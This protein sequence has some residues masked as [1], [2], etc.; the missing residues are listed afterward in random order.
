[1]PEMGQAQPGAASAIAVWP[2]RDQDAFERGQQELDSFSCDALSYTSDDLVHLTLEIFIALGFPNK[3]NISVMKLKKFILCVRTCMFDN[4]YHNWFHAFDVTQ[5]TYCLAIKSGMHQTLSDVELFALIVSALCH[6][7]EHPG[8][9]NPFLV[10]SRSDL[11]TLYN[12]RSVLENHHCCRAFQLILHSEIQLLSEFSGQDY[13]L[14]RTAVLSNI[15]ATDMARHGD[16]TTK[17]KRLTEASTP[18]EDRQIDSQFAMEVIIKCA[19]TSNVLKPFAIAKK[20]AMRV[21]DEFFLQGDKERANSMPLTPMCDRTS[22]GRVALQKGFVDFVI[23][24]FY[25]LV[26]DAMPGLKEGFF[27][28]WQNREA[29]NQYDDQRLL[30]ELGDDY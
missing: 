1:M 30:E 10:A 20:W 21:T 3:V 4:P 17:L 7:L 8:V 28:L 27:L 25:K 5:T 13:T 11:A 15:L 16:Y 22:Q 18:L 26:G 12:D 23:G 19:D 6:D 9:N 14:F 24:P 29:W 2:K